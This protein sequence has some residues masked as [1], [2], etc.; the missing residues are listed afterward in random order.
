MIPRAPETL[1]DAS[2]SSLHVVH[3]MISATEALFARSAHGGPSMIG[4]V[5]EERRI[6]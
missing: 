4:Q 6:K 2:S 3:P 1:N 5:S